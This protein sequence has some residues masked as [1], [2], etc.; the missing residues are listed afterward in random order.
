MKD[1][2]SA[3][4]LHGERLDNWRNSLSSRVSGS[5]K[6]IRLY[7]F[8]QLRGFVYFNKKIIMIIKIKIIIKIIIIII[9]IIIINSF[10][11]VS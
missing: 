7:A 5:H 11:L 1:E 4:N 10:S 3:N 2:N 9:I 6:R 8:L